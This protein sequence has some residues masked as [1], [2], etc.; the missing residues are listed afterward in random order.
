M[1]VARYYAE[2]KIGHIT[3]GKCLLVAGGVTFGMI[4]FILGGQNDLGTTII[5]IVGILA[6]L[7]IAG[8]PTPVFIGIVGVCVLF[9]LLVVFGTS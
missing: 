4:L 9:G 8:I 3:W 2:Y 5:C 1:I 6:L 7:L